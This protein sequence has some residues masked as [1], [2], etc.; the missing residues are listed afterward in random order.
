MIFPS[1]EEVER[2][3]DSRF[4]LTL[5]VAERAKQIRGVEGRLATDDKGHPVTLALEEL[6]DTDIDVDLSK[7]IDPGE[8]RTDDSGPGLA[9]QVEAKNAVSSDSKVEVMEGPESD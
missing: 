6:K 1:L 5:V 3:I 4:L 2:K 7:N 9:P 8:V